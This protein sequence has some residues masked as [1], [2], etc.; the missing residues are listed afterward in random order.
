MNTTTK[1]SSSGGISTIS[2]IQI[3]L[4]ILKWC[5]LI[6]WSW[7]WVLTPFWGSLTLSIIIFLIYVI[8]KLAVKK[9]I[10]RG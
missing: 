5:K 8:V 4:L 9:K 1:S 7:F 10:N 2:V 6:N 3:T